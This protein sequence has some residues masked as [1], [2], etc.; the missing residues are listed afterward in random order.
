MTKY[1][2]ELYGVLSSNVLSLKCKR[3]V[4][5]L[6]VSEVVSCEVIKITLEQL[7]RR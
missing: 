1:L 5:V 3:C 2:L 6:I 4:F 7:L